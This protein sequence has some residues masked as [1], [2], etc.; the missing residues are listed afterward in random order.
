MASNNETAAK[1]TVSYENGKDE[2]DKVSNL[3]QE[4]P[5]PKKDEEVEIKAPAESEPAVEPSE[6]PAPA[7]APA[8]A[9]E[10]EP[11]PEHEPEPE[12][13]PESEP[14]AFVPK[15]KYTEGLY[16]IIIYIIHIQKIVIWK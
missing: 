2:T 15:Y 3:E 6:A 8:A 5:L 16:L 14:P 13:A 7:P 10:P 11:E 4:K 9:P 12:P 1:E